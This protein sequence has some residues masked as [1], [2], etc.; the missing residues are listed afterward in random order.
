MVSLRRSIVR[1]SQGRINRHHTDAGIELGL[2]GP[3]P[4]TIL[5]WQVAGELLRWLRKWEAAGRVSGADVENHFGDFLASFPLVLPAPQVFIRYFDLHTR[6][7]RWFV[8]WESVSS[9]LRLQ[10]RVLAA[11]GRLDLI[12]QA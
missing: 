9:R 4:T 2:M 10:W 7:S 5:T 8:P 11:L 3:A 12:A 1:R 6:F